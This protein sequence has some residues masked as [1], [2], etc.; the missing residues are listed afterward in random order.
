MKRV[1]A[2]GLV[3]VVFVVGLVAGGLG[4]RLLRV[5]APAGGARFDTPPFQRYFMHGDLDLSREQRTQLEEV[6][7][8]QRGKFEA[9]HRD[10]R[11]QVEA[12]MDETQAE[13]EA[14]LTPE[15]LERFRARRNRWQRRRDRHGPPHRRFHEETPALE[16]PPPGPAPSV[17]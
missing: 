15:Q 12:L 2:I 16:E 14:I 1:T 13:L 10:L 5:G 4:A 6:F 7:K 11:P 8:R 3:G 9:L 17:D